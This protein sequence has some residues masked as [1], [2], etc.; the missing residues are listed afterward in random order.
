MIHMNFNQEINFSINKGLNRALQFRPELELL[1]LISG[2]ADVEIKDTTYHLEQEEFLLINSGTP[3]T[4]CCSSNAIFANATFSQS[5]LAQTAYENKNLFLFSTHIKK[6]ADYHEVIQLIREIIYN[7]VYPNHKSTCYMLSLLLK[8]MDFLVE[9]YQIDITKEAT[10]QESDDYRV[11]EII[12]YV[13]Q[14]YREDLSLSDLAEQMYTSKSTLSRLFKKQTG[15]YFTDYVNQIRIRSSVQD[16]MHTDK[17]ITRIALDNG[18]SNPS[19]FHRVFTGYYKQSPSEFKKEQKIKDAEKQKE[20]ISI[21]EQLKKQLEKQNPPSC[22]GNRIGKEQYSI[23]AKTGTPLHK[24]WSHMI[25]VG[26][27]HLLTLANVQFHTLYLFEHL[28]IQYVRLWNIFSKKLMITDDIHKNSYNFE[29]VDSIFD[30]LVNNH[31]HPYIDFCCRPDIALSASK[32]FIY[33]EDNHI[34]FKSREA[35]E[36]AFQNLINHLTI[37]YGAEEIR[38]WIFEFGQVPFLVQNI[39][40]YEDEHYDYFDAYQFFY[41]TLKSHFPDALVGSVPYLASSGYEFI[42]HFLEKCKSANCVPD[43]IPCVLFPYDI[44]A[45]DP[46]T[47]QKTLRE[48]YEVSELEKLHELLKRLELNSCKIFISEYNNS[49]SNRNHMNDSSFRASFFA[50]KL[51]EMNPLVDQICLWTASDWVSNYYDTRS[52]VNGGSGLLTKDT[53]RKPA[54]YAIHFLNQLGET[55]I[56]KGENFI[57]TAKGEQHFYILCFNHKQYNSNYY[58]N[59]EGTITPD[60]INKMLE[61]SNPVDIDLTL[62]NLPDNTRYIVKRRTINQYSG[63]IL[64]EWKKFHYYT[65]LSSNDIKYMR[66]VCIPDMSMEKLISIKGKIQ[67]KITLQSQEVSLLHIYK[68]P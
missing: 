33:Y 23:D 15:T 31:I 38:K 19:A 14:N 32:Q 1:F 44:N 46:S 63:N 5:L 10:P 52:I 12:K 27:S 50:K 28:R 26:S 67:I 65:E 37:R 39:N 58:M 11:Q 25:N 22:N 34:P 3:H 53:I 35:W 8:L 21:R 42:T 7:E 29:T 41:T 51:S 6:N 45:V 36:D 62:F 16:L 61:N 13:C 43:F 68:E 59:D 66:S 24:N 18:F 40:C 64:N 4:L 48:N 30:F 56:G 55:L 49:L 17:N 20:N 47:Y 9:H 57:A 54:Y 2:T 60:D